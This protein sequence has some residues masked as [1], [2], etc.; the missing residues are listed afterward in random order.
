MLLIKNNVAYFQSLR[1]G[2]C[3]PQ[4]ES[5]VKGNTLVCEARRTK[6]GL[7]SDKE[8]AFRPLPL[9]RTVRESFPSHSSSLYEASYLTQLSV[10]L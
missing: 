8:A 9:L 2:R 10:H 6:M 7:L 1:N 3:S 4:S 5:E